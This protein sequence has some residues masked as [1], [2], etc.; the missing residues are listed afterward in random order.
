MEEQDYI[1]NTQQ[2]LKDIVIK[3]NFCPFANQPFIQNT[4]RYRV[5]AGKSL[6]EIDHILLEECQYL[7][8]HPETETTLIILADALQQFSAF[9]TYIKRADRLLF[10]KKIVSKYQIAHFHPDYEFAQHDKDDSAN[11]TNRSPHPVLHL[12]RQKSITRALNKHPDANQ[13][14]ENNIHTARE[15]GITFFE[16]FLRSMQR[17]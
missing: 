5:I 16:T 11:Y 3:L 12:I 10:K 7:D 2:W 14:P 1:S 6:D 15:K 8:S 17:Y 9:N 13:I 4:I